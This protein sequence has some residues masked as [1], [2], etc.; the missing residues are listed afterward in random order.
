MISN[1]IVCR[2]YTNSLSFLQHHSDLAKR[3]KGYD[4]YDVV[5]GN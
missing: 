3:S 1:R 2:A 4:R 5:A